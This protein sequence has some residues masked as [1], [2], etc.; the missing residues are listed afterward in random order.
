MS[1]NTIFFFFRFLSEIWRL[2]RPRSFL[3]FRQTI[4]CGFTLKVIRDMVITYSQMHRAGKYSQYSLIIWPIWVNGW[5]FIYELSGC[6]FRSRCCHL[7]LNSMRE[8]LEDNRLR[9]FCHLQRM[10]VNVW[11]CRCRT[12]KA[13]MCF[14]SHPPRDVIFQL[15][16][17]SINVIAWE[18][19]SKIIW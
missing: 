18:F 1:S 19:L 8:C 2:L 12:F 10:E 11:S 15:I 4:E 3:T 13:D 14:S 17:H 9:S 16:F 5:V 7:K 6:G